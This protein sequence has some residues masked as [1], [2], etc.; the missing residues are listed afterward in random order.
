MTPGYKGPSRRSVAALLLLV[1]LLTVLTVGRSNPS[2]HD[3]VGLP[4]LATKTRWTM[5]WLLLRYAGILP[6]L[7]ARQLLA[8][9]VGLRTSE[10][11]FAANH[12]AVHGRGAERVQWSSTLVSHD[13]AAEAV[14]VE[15]VD[16]A[17][18]LR[19]VDCMAILEAKRAVSALP[20]G[21][22]LQVQLTAELRAQTPPS[23]DRCQ[24]MNH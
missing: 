12:L 6:A 17:L 2:S 22:D 15:A 24:R 9:D 20:Q 21:S 23:G 16:A 3:A 18:H 10:A 5:S 19:P 14:L 8:L 7:S 4:R 11:R 13:A 1:A